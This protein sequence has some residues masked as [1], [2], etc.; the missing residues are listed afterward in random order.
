MPPR[1]QKPTSLNPT[2][3]RNAKAREQMEAPNNAVL[4]FAKHENNI[5]EGTRDSL[6]LNK[7]ISTDEYIVAFCEAL[8]TAHGKIR[9]QQAS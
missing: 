5:T 8:L 6:R 1:L 3:P 4:S 2:T 7:R 9:D